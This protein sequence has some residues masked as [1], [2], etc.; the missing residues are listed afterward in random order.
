MAELNKVR[1][2]FYGDFWPLLSF[3]LSDETWALWQYDR[4]DLG[5]GMILAL[6]RKDSLFA[7][8]TA[9]LRGL[10]SKATYE[11][12][13]LDDGKVQKISGKKLCES[14]LKI[15]INDQPGSKLFIYKESE[16]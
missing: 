2:Y 3:S 9:R 1:K 7:E 13:N 15:E 4:P 16:K 12:R 5:E 14:G 10:D 8:V 11:L 6:R